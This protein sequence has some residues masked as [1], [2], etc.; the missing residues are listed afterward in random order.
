MLDGLG[1]SIRER[2]YRETT[3]ADIVRHAKTS[4]RT[5][6]GQFASKDDCLLELLDIDNDRMIADI[7]AAVDPEADWYTQVE[8]AIDSYVG[9]IES[10][11]PIWLTWIREFPALG[12]AARSVQRRGMQRFT[13]MLVDL[14]ANPG[15]TRA[16]LP[17]ISRPLALILLG[18]LR[19]L[20]A[21]TLEDGGDIRGIA[22][23]AVA[24]SAALL[25][26][27]HPQ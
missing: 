24:A 3:V 15:F 2:G 17:P 12:E 20:T 11:P 1:Q 26:Y 4:K 23:T 25:R 6:Y 16:D 13:D 22:G 19:E 7:R 9:T 14:S 18:G 5:F 27:G 21:L 10:R 8:Q